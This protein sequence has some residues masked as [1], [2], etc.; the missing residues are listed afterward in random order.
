MLSHKPEIVTRLR[1]EHDEIFGP[2]TN[3]VSS[4]LKAKPHLINELPWTT[5]VIKES[6]RFF[7][8]ASSLRAA[9]DS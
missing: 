3:A 2:D 7:A 6:M 1:C 4:V 5:A 9:D 8:P